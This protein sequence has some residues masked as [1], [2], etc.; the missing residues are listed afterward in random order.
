[1]IM[2][3]WSALLVLFY[4]AG[5][6]RTSAQSNYYEDEPKVF[7]GG[8]ILGAVFS[9]IDGDT[10]FGYH[11]VGVNFGGRVYAHFTPVFGASLEIQYAQKGSRGEAVLESPT[12]GT[13]VTKYYM[14]VNYV[15]LPLTLHAILYTIDIEAGVSYA[16]L[17]R[18]KEWILADKPVVIDPE[19]ARFNTD[20]IGYVFGIGR[21]VYKGLH[22]NLRFQYSMVSIR[23]PER[24]PT[25]Q[26]YGNIGQ[27]NNLFNF[28]LIYL[29]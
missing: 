29:F 19:K 18:S 10:Y 22:A 20:E 25:N 16:R 8:L 2:F 17:V 23:P 9:Q 15:E 27:F 26:G 5:A 1:M 6:L 28:R 3:R 14:N 7:E 21:K 11:K 24:I 12:I 13:Y 4:L